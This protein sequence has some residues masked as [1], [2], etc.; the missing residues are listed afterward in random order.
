[1]HFLSSGKTHVLLLWLSTIAPTTAFLPSHQSVVQNAATFADRAEPWSRLD[2]AFDS[3]EGSNI[4]DGPMALTKERDAC[5]VGFVSN[6]N[7]GKLNGNGRTDYLLSVV[8]N[9]MF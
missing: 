4:Y 2:M 9:S 3:S 8:V 5:G 6:T 7:E 1:M